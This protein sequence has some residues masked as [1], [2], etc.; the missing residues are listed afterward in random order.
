VQARRL[1]AWSRWTMLHAAG[2]EAWHYA[3]AAE[4]T[5][6]HRRVVLIECGSASLDAWLALRDAVAP[7]TPGL[8]VRCVQGDHHPGLPRGVTVQ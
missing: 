1:L 2:G 5:L 3:L 8:V 6:A 4:A 7:S